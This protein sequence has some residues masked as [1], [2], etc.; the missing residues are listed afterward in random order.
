MVNL[1]EA[2]LKFNVY[3]ATNASGIDG[4]GWSAPYPGHFTPGKDSV[5]TVWEAGWAGDG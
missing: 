3:Q 5:P 2:G 1:F 4:V